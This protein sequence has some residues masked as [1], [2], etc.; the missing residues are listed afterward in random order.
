M[1]T[2]RYLA[3]VAARLAPFRREPAVE[4]LLVEMRAMGIV[5]SAEGQH[6]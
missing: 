2:V 5:G 1:R 3:D 6:V 4:G